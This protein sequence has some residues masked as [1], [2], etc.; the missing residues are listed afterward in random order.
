M[1]LDHGTIANTILTAPGWA[2]AGI[3]SAA[4]HV[5]EDAAS[6]LARAIL[7]R[8]TC[9]AADEPDPDQLGLAL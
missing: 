2:R 9:D 6:E 4:D 3:T 1:R 7:E 8:V 5:R